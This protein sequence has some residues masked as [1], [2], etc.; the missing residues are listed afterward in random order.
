MAVIFSK[1]SGSNDSFWKDTDIAITSVIKDADLVQNDDD[2][3]LKAIANQEKSTKWAEKR[4][5]LT[6][7]GDFV[8]VAE[9]GA[10]VQ[11]DI[12]EGYP[13]LVQMYQFL[14]HFICTAEAQ[15]DMNIS[16]MRDKAVSFVN[17]YKRSKAQFATNLLTSQ[18]TT[19]SFGGQS[20]DTTT[21]DGKALFATD[22]PSIRGGAAQ[23]N[24]FTN[25]F[26][27]DSR[28]LR[29][30]ASIIRNFKDDNGI[31]LGYT[32]DTIM[33]PGNCWELEETIKR[34]IGS[35][36]IIGSSNNDI[37]TQKGKWNLIVNHLWTADTGENPYIVYSEKARKDMHGFDFFDRVPLAVRNEIDKST[38]NL[39]WYGRTRFGAGAFNWRWAVMGGAKTGD[40][41]T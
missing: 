32:A 39:E 41:L 25:A 20:F 36:L 3:L 40:T 31:V 35:D 21:G 33:I 4:T 15:E 17:S 10:S 24:K 28:M 22:H 19:A 30:M 8:P 27:S 34:L 18:G 13:K 37:N 6:Q 29:Q 11:D 1:S 16:E 5:T 2:K 14:K 23:S 7:F 9:G 38:W 26:G 12:R